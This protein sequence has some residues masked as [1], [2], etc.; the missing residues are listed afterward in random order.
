MTRKPAASIHAVIG[1]ERV[2]DSYVADR[3][4]AT[5]V[6][7]ALGG[8]RQGL[9]LLRGEEATWTQLLDGLRSR[10]LFSNRRAVVVRN[11]EALKGDAEAFLAWLAEPDPD[12]TLV[13]VAAKPD[14]RKAVWK[15]LLERA[16]LVRAEPPKGAGLRRYVL[17]GVRQRQLALTPEGTDELLERAS[18]E[19]RRLE[20]ELDRLAAFG[21]DASRPLD[22]QDVVAVIGRGRAQPLFKLADAVSERDVEG[23]LTRVQELLDEGEDPLRLLGTLYRAV[24]QLAK[25]RALRGSGVGRDQ[26]AQQLGLPPHMAFKLPDILRAAERW[27]D[28][29]LDAAF[30]AFD[31]ADRR[32]KTSGVAEVTLA[33]AV[34][35]AC[36]SGAAAT[37]PPR[38][39]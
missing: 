21:Q 1:G 36:G 24:R 19:L 34:A 10:S 39:R 23:S 16:E 6:S 14:R 17:E 9:S 38:G 30:T 28:A 29:T 25:A 3:A 15:R 20:S 37:S 5:L 2:F 22:A 31:R 8:E 27:N 18:T 35:R 26:M 12:V 32:L 4:V 33:Q 13:V 11:A 7:A